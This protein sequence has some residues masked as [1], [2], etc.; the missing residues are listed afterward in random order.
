MNAALAVLLVIGF[1]DSS[2][3]CSALGG[4]TIDS[5]AIGLPTRGAVITT[6]TSVPAADG[7]TNANGTFTKALPAYCKVLGTITPIDPAAPN[8]RFEVNLPDNWNRRML[9]MGG[10]GFNGTLVTGLGDVPSAPLDAPLPLMRG[11]VTYGSDS[12][13]DA[14]SLPEPQA[15]ALNDEALVNFAH[16][17]YKK[18]HDVAKETTRLYYGTA[19]ERSY[20]VGSSEGGREGLAMA[21]RYP[22]DFDGIFSRVPVI[23]WVGLQLAGNRTGTVQTKGGW[24]NAAKAK[25]VHEAVLAT[26]D[27]LDRLADGIV[28]DY[29]GCARR[30]DVATLRCPDGSDSGDACLSDAQVAAVR[31]LREPYQFAFP[32]ANGV[33]HYP[34]WGYG[35]EMSPGGWNLWFNGTAAPGFPATAANG[36]AYRFGSGAMRYFIAKDPTLDTLAFSPDKH[37]KRLQ[38][39]SSLMDATNPDLSAFAARGGKLI[40]KEHT[41]DYAQSPFAGIE[42][43]KSVVNRMGQAAVDRFFRLYVTPGANHGGGNVPDQVDVLT[44]LEAWTERNEAPPDAPTQVLQ[45][46]A[47][48]FAITMS[49]PM[50]RYPKFPTYDGKGDPQLASSF[51]CD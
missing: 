37:Q 36:T 39:V 25:R 48:P 28:S 20:W 43:Y 33:T 1:Q 8:I 24:P 14:M 27:T 47:P 10:G 30:F 18:T 50:C 17:A 31:T 15:F 41:G 2:S 5:S 7:R 44:L 16:A 46:G 4:S 40:L 26:C 29:E 38:E 35:G 22:Q 34:G 23:N 6:A 13:H 49:R 45:A 51:R 11:Y 32:L 9:G 3:R 19:P 42:Y 21:Q 12:G